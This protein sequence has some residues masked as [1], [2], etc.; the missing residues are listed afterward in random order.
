MIFG[1]IYYSGYLG[2]KGKV[3]GCEWNKTR[4]VLPA[5]FPGG[6]VSKESAAMWEAWV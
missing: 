1:Y 3:L 2:K 6:S 4:V 5:G